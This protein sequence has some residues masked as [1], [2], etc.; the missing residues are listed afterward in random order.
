MENIDRKKFFKTIG[1]GALVVA[2]SSYLP[3]KFLSKADKISKQSNPKI[4]IHP[5]AVKRNNKV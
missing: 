3:V 2:L 4:K 1:K 5:S